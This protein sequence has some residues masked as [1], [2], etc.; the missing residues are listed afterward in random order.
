MRCSE[1]D[2]VVVADNKFCVPLSEEI[3]LNRG[4]FVERSRLVIV[5]K[6][7]NLPQEE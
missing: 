7:M 5:L 2:E 6:I 4:D 1:G 3:R